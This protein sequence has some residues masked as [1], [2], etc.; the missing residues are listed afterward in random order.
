[1]DEWIEWIEPAGG[2]RVR[3]VRGRATTGA[4]REWPD[5]P[6]WSAP[7]ARA[8]CESTTSYAPVHSI[9]IQIQIKIELN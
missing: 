7:A 2:N 4:A 8:I 5:R 9:Q 6:T 1:M 3:S